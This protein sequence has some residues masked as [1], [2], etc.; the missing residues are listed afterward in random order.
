M[1]PIR[2]AADEQAL[3][4]ART[5]LEGSGE[6]LKALGAQ[7]DGKVVV[8]STGGHSGY[9]LRLNDGDWVAVWLDV[10][11]GRMEFS[12]GDGAPPERLLALLSSPA[13][14]DA[15]GPLDVDRIYANQTNDIAAEARRTHGQPIC[16]VAIGARDF[17]LCFP[18]GMELEGNVF[19]T[20]AGRLALRVFYEQW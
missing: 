14:A 6:A 12:V 5:L 3:S 4:T 8:D 11:A 17:S 20:A 19:E 1:P 15:S 18:D 2:V 13:V 16:G 7:L 9:L 10:E